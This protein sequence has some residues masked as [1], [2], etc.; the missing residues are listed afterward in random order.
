MKTTPSMIRF[1][2]CLAISAAATGWAQI[3]PRN[4]PIVRPP[5]LHVDVRANEKPMTIDSYSVDAQ[6]NGLFASVR[7]LIVFG[8]PNS[9]VLEG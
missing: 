2:A 6:V 4:L 8:N 5:V 7:T 9:R 1:I 3:V